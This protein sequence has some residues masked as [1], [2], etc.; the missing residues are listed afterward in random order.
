MALL[1]LQKRGRE[2]GRIRI[3]A[4]VAYE[5]DGKERRRPVK[6]E[7]FR[8]TTPS[9]RNARLVAEKFGG[10]ARPWTDRPGQWEVLT[11][12][13]E[14]PV[15]VPPGHPLT[16]S[17]ELW[18]GGG[19]QRRCNG[20]EQEN[21]HACVC[22]ADIGKRMEAAA[23]GNACKPASRLSVVLP[24][25]MDLGVWLVVSH[26][27]NAALELQGAT[28][29]LEQAASSDVF[30]PAMLRLEQRQKVVNGQTL[31][32]G[33]PVL[34]VGATLRA[35]VAGE[36]GRDGAMALP[37][38]PGVKELEAG[39]T[40]PPAPR[41]DEPDWIPPVEREVDDDG[42]V[43][44]EIVD[45]T[46]DPDTIATN[47]LG[48]LTRDDVQQ[49]VNQAAHAGLLGKEATHPVNGRRMILRELLQ[50]RWRELPA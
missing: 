34:E 23:A 39:H 17:Y 40:Q 31:K 15:M 38:P 48:C 20:V 18:S 22:P 6:L 16:Q 19:I 11:E 41:L 46:P 49:L 26:G 5:K 4:T 45:E 2:L 9:E 12:A 35:L 13:T 21:G 32:W 3:G 24:D 42:I 10:E 7:S 37:P 44:A 29:F 27:Y 28:D 43:D 50:A 33:V 47:S 25:L 36:Y 1:D 30:L 14:L 8:L